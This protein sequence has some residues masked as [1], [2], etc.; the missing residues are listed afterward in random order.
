MPRVAPSIATF[1]GPPGGEDTA[2]PV[3]LHSVAG[4][5]SETETH[6]SAPV[7]HVPYDVLVAYAAGA[8]TCAVELLVASHLTFCAACR[9]TVADAEALGGALLLVAAPVPVSGFPDLDM[10]EE[11]PVPMPTCSVLPAPVRS[12]TGPHSGLAWRNVGRGLRI[13]PIDLGPEPRRTFLLELPAGCH[14]PAHGHRGTERVLVLQGGFT[15]GD[16]AFGVGDVSWH[17]EA[18][19][20]VHIDAD[21]P[22]LALFVNDGPFVVGGALG[23][24]LLDHWLGR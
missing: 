21:G 8:A 3:D 15:D 6:L 1:N 13:T 14:V 19:H 9:A 22:C 20:R 11:L 5:R 24:R 23:T 16:D 18:G 17:D 7:H 2:R 12:R 10:P 4:R